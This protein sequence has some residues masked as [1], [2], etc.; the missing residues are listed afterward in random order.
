MVYFR[1]VDYGQA[2]RLAGLV[3]IVPGFRAEYR[4]GFNSFVLGLVVV[5]G[6]Y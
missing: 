1:L 6:G 3:L 5:G 2:S 4:G